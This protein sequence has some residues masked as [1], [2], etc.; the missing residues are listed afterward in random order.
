MPPALGGGR[1]GGGSGV[2]ETPRIW[3]RRC[4]PL[5]THALDGAV[6]TTLPDAV[7]SSTDE[8]VVDRR[9][10]TVSTRLVPP[11]P[12]C[13]RVGH[14]ARRRSRCHTPAR[15]A[16]D[17][18]RRRCHQ[19]PNTPRVIVVSHRPGDRSLAVH[20]CSANAP[21]TS[22]YCGAVRHRQ[23]CS[24]VSQPKGWRRRR[25]APY[26]R[27]ASLLV[28]SYLTQYCTCVRPR[29]RVYGPP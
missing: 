20:R 27:R 18:Q 25:P 28:P 24:N 21:C 1:A 13:R 3:S 10:R 29:T 23:W 6:A 11:D 8:H 19:G 22:T 9:R 4:G 16:Y 26:A 17:A 15:R 14:L 2:E 7:P 12:R 5:V